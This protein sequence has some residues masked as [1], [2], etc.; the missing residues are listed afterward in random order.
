MEE[1]N[2]KKSKSRELITIICLSL[3]IIVSVAILIVASLPNQGGGTTILP[4]TGDTKTVVLSFSSILGPITTY[5]P[6]TLALNIDAGGS[7]VTAA[8]VEL[9]YDVS[10][11]Q[12]NS[13]TQGDFFA[14]VLASPTITAGKIM[15]TYAVA[16]DSGGKLGTGTVATITFQAIAAGTTNIGFTANTLASAIGNA[17]DVIKTKTDATISSLLPS[18][19]PTNTPITQ[20]LAPVTRVQ[21]SPSAR[22]MS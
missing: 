3:I 9:S 7:K 22:P 19:T 14:N 13:V 12:I 18:P 15:F 16:P 21:V 11:L 4:E 20:I 8:T 10:K 1:V 5:T 6:T 2:K 17:G